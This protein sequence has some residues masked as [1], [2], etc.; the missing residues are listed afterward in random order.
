MR[1]S[2]QLVAAATSLAKP[3]LTAAERRT[4]RPWWI[5]PSRRDGV[6][7]IAIEPKRSADGLLANIAI[8]LSLRMRVNRMMNDCFKRR[9][10]GAGVRSSGRDRV[11]SRLRR[12]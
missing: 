10:G 7:F 5:A 2:Y 8:H 9:A 4:K 11:G 1:R 6:G 3:W 12:G